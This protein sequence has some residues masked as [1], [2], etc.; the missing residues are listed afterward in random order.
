MN[1][2]ACD[3]SEEES[4]I[5]SKVYYIDESLDIQQFNFIINNTQSEKYN[6]S[7]HEESNR[8][9]TTDHSGYIELNISYRLIET[10]NTGLQ[11][12]NEVNTCYM[13][14]WQNT[15]CCKTIMGVYLITYLI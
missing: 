5:A 11:C 2:T 8:I 12:I 9:P 3:Y 1:I 15:L 7:F 13:Y 6:C 14:I 4:V 10:P